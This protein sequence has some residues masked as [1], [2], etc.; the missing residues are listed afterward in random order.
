MKGAAAAV[1][2]AVEHGE[3]GLDVLSEGLLA[4]RVADELG[5][6][7]LLVLVLAQDISDGCGGSLGQE[8]AEMQGQMQ[9]RIQG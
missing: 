9:G 5:H 7:L 8:S 6:V 1:A 4:L 2:V 3:P